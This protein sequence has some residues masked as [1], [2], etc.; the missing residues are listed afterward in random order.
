MRIFFSVG[1]PSGDVHGANLIRAIQQHRSDVEF[2]GF[3]GD[4]MAEAGCRHLFN[5]CEHAVMG[6]TRVL[7]ALPQF[8]S[9]IS[10]ADRY[11]HHHRPDAVV[12][13]DYPGFNWWIA[14]RAKYHR[15]PV[16][17]FVPPQ[18]WAWAGWRV[19]KMRSYV[20][21]V[22]CSLPFEVDWYR[23]RGVLQA[24]YVGHPFFDECARQV[25]DAG[26]L[27]Q[28]RHQPGTIIGILPGSRDQEVQANLLTQ[29]KAAQRIHEAH[30][31][32]RFLVASYNASQQKMVEEM[33]QAF[34]ALPIQTHVG[35]TPEI[36]ELSKA[37]IAVSGSVSLELLYRAKPTVIVYQVG[38]FMDWFIRPLLT[39][40]YITLVNLLADRM[41]FPEFA[42]SRCEADGIAEVILNWLNDDRAYA[43]LCRNLMAL[44]EKTAQ[45]GACDRAAQRIL[46]VAEHNLARA[47]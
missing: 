15:I 22:L 31:E 26:F 1:E 32:T 28:Q 18:L 45:P 3:G 27:H 43:G 4:R 38:W 33:L 30:P 20:D 34:P 47:A 17:Y 9:L 36:I 7:T 10:Q 16:F 25:L 2:V 35:R 13:I 37:C 21:H 8:L 39:V 42:S 29:L 44:R 40:K 11:L 23:E 12:L 41:L 24:E 19:S 46:G 6:I 5:L 14:S